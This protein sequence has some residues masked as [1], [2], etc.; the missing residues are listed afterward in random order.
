MYPGCEAAPV[1][2]HVGLL[3]RDEAERRAMLATLES[4]CGPVGRTSGA[5]HVHLR[6]LRHKLETQNR[7]RP[8]VTLFFFRRRFSCPWPEYFSELDEVTRL[9]VAALATSAPS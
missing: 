9:T 8:V 5:R 6:V 1:E 2:R 4:V 7:P 3:P